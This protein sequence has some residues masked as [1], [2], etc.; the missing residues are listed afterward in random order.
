MI[1]RLELSNFKCFSHQEFDF[2]KLT[3]FCGY[4]AA[5]KSSV[6]QSLLI[7]QQASGTAVNEMTSIPLNG[8]FG[9]ELGTVADVFSH[10]ATAPFIQ[11]CLIAGGKATK[12]ICRADDN[13][14][15]KHYLMAHV[16][17]N[18]VHEILPT[19]EAFQFTYLSAERLGPRDTQTLQSKS[20][21]ELSVG[22]KGEF[23]AEV[24]SR[25]ERKEIRAELCHPDGGSD[26]RLLLYQLQLWMREWA[27]GLDIKAEMFPT[28]NIAAIRVRKRNVESEWMRPTNV[29]FGISHSLPIVLAGLLAN[30]G[31]MLIIDSPESHLHPKGQLAIGQFIAV[32]AESGVQVIVETH[33][34]HVLNGIRLATKRSRVNAEHVKIYF[35]SDGEDSQS[36]KIDCPKL[37]QNGKLTSWPEGFFDQWQMALHELL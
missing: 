7:A 37:M 32:I 5:G 28:T 19:R 16:N 18:A 25:F 9:L 6:V 10:D 26:N 23:S 3:V 21:E 14:L 33:S 8:P 12:V 35:F 15:D 24:L 17:D 29:G 22:V 1:E 34:D 27:P 20:D 30:E 13:D 2:N 4:N 11:I 31:G 36:T